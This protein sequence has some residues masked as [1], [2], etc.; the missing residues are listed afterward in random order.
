MRFVI[1]LLFDE[2]SFLCTEVIVLLKHTYFNSA[3]FITNKIK[4]ELITLRKIF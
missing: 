2:N 4:I 1:V 3:E